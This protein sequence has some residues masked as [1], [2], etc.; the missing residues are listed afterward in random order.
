MAKQSNEIQWLLDRAAIHDV[1]ARYFHGI[2]ARS[3]DQVRGCFTDDIVA[4]YDGRA[5][6]KGIEAL[7]KS[8]Y[9]FDRQKSGEWKVTTHFMGNLNYKSLEGDVAETETNAFAF[10]VLP[11]A[12][13][14]Q[15]AMRSLRYL[16]KLR[17]SKDG[18]QI[19]ER[20][21]TL[22]WSCQVPTTFA[23]TTARRMTVRPS[24]A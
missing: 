9:A 22:D 3:Q 24:G 10:L 5:P 16:D 23:L 15:V 14:E 19:S 17:R 4:F 7:M 1:L 11:G 8:F 20:M 12:A 13:G 2:D 21:H 18:W 6:V